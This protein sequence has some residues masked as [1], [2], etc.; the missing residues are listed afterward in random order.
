MVFDKKTVGILCEFHISMQVGHAVSESVPVWAPQLLLSGHLGFSFHTF[1]DIYVCRPT[2][3]KMAPN[4]AICCLH[5]VLACRPI[6]CRPKKSPKL[7]TLNTGFSPSNGK[8]AVIDRAHTRC[9][10][11]R[12]MLFTV[13]YDGSQNCYYPCMHTGCSA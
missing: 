9:D 1:S 2:V 13:R 4:H 3:C 10:C 12:K 5:T 6:V 11:P 8:H 7:L